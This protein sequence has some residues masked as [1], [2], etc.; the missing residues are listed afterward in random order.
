MITR[1]EKSLA[2]SCQ[3]EIDRVRKEKEKQLEI[4][5]KSQK[6]EEKATIKEELQKQLANEKAIKIENETI[7]EYRIYF[8]PTDITD[9]N[10]EITKSIEAIEPKY[11]VYDNRAEKAKIERQEKALASIAGGYVKI[12][13]CLHICL[14]PGN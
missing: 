1:K 4:Q 12:H 2:I 5:Y 9:K 13:T 6:N 8:R 3:A 7:R 14:L 10:S 11:L